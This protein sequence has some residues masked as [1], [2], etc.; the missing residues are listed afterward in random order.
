LKCGLVPPKE[1]LL[2]LPLP[3]TLRGDGLMIT[4]LTWKAET[5][6]LG[7]IKRAADKSLGLVH[8]QHGHV[9]SATS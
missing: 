9:R 2:F 4:E 8:A 7:K 6:A 5:K 1:Q 3:T